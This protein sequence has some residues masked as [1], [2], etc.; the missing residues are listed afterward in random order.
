MSM[1]KSAISNICKANYCVAKFNQSEVLKAVITD[2]LKFYRKSANKTQQDIADILGV[3]KSA[4]SNYEL[5]KRKVPL[6]TLKRLAEYYH[7]SADEFMFDIPDNAIRANFNDY[8]KIPIVKK[9]IPGAKCFDDENISGYEV[10]NLKEIL[11]GYKYCYF[12]VHGDS[13]EPIIF[14]KDLIL[15][16]I[17]PDIDNGD[18]AVMLVGENPDN[19]ISFVRCIKKEKSKMILVSENRYYP[20]KEFAGTNLSHLQ[21][22]G[23]V[24]EIK[25]KL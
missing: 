17:Q 16:R 23:R 15:V 9:C 10:I 13:M 19:L 25:R 20:P 1:L 4:Y 24:I 7:I 3:T 21:V 5:G 2:K 18:I 6:K 14:D 22:F 11:H 12:R 8:I